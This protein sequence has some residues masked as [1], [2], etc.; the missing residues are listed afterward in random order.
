MMFAFLF[1]KTFDESNCEYKAMNATDG[2]RKN[3][4]RY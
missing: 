3:I 2:C 4:N 1:L